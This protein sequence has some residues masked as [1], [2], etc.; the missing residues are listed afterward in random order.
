MKPSA[1]LLSLLAAPLMACLPYLPSE[2]QRDVM[3]SSGSAPPCQEQLPPFNGPEE[4]RRYAT[5]CPGE[6]LQAMKLQQHSWALE[7]RRSHAEL[8][9]L[10][11][12]NAGLQ[13]E[14]DAQKKNGRD[15]LKTCEK[16]CNESETSAMDYIRGMERRL[17]DLEEENKSLKRAKQGNCQSQPPSS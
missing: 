16:S 1:V 15:N 4:L 17:G 10:R 2:H 9:I 14:L 11:E 8:A 7:L 12:T 3:P 6:F 5:A 13:R